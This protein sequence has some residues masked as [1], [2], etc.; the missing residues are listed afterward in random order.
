MSGL[1]TAN[2]AIDEMWMRRALSLA[3]QAAAIGEIPVGAVVIYQGK[4]IAES[5]NRKESTNDPL[6]HAETLAIREAAMRLGR[7]RLSGCTLYVTLEPCAM[8][9]GAVIQARLDRVVYATPD[10]KAGAVRSLY[11]LLSDPRLNHTP[12]I[13][14]GILQFEAADLL[15]NFFRKLRSPQ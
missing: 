12:Q 15:K 11:N 10:P 6:G 5:G 4:A 3:A 7:W 8:C 14:E 1:S 2:S 9:A 13:S